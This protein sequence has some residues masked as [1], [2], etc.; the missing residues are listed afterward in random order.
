MSHTKEPEAT[1]T[2]LAL[3]QMEP[4]PGMVDRGAE[5]SEIYGN[6]ITRNQARSIW[7][8]MLVAAVKEKEND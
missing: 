7:T 4:T 5:V 2:L 3:S 6:W 1:A 8:A